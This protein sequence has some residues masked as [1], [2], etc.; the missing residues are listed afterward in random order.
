LDYW[1]FTYIS[2][3]THALRRKSIIVRRIINRKSALPLNGGQQQ[4]KI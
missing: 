2:L 1:K 4:F 3:L